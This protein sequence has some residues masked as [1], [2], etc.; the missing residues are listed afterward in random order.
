MGTE[1]SFHQG[2]P[3][4]FQLTCCWLLSARGWQNG[5]VGEEMVVRGILMRLLN[6]QPN[7]WNIF[8][9]FWQSEQDCSLEEKDLCVMFSGCFQLLV[10]VLAIGVN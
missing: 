3:S 6:S 4:L 2:H 8:Q 7:T 10:M 1:L 9:N 5:V